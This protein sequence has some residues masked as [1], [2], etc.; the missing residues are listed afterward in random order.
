MWKDVEVINRKFNQWVNYKDTPLSISD[1]CYRMKMKESD[2]ILLS[3]F[4]SEEANV[5]QIDAVLEW[6]R[7]S[8]MNEL[9]FEEAKQIMKRHNPVPVFD[10]HKAFKKLE[11]KLH[12]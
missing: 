11:K 4:L 2:W 12:R 3:L 9:V 8:S 6:R 10:S 5:E 7:A 1:N